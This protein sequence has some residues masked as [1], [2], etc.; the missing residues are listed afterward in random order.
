M[1][2]QNRISKGEEKPLVTS[3]S[4]D[5]E[6]DGNHKLQLKLVIWLCGVAQTTA[7]KDTRLGVGL[8]SN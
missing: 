2:N 7:A 6:I 1:I 8:R 3:C 5:V 4:G